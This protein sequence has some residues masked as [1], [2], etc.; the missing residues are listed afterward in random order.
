MGE[1]W[2]WYCCHGRHCCCYSRHGK[3]NFLRDCKTNQCG[4]AGSEDMSCPAANTTSLETYSTGVTEES[5]DA[6]SAKVAVVEA[7]SAEGLETYF[8]GGEEISIDTKS[9]KEAVVEVGRRG[10][11]CGPDLSGQW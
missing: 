5:I 4:Q 10:G 11:G 8:A 3:C 1:G 7:G 6:M 2:V 9:A